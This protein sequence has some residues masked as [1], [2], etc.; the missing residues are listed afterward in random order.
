MPQAVAPGPLKPS[1]AWYILGALLIVAAIAAPIVVAAA[2]FGRFGRKVA[3]VTEEAPVILEADVPGEHEV[4][5]AFPG[6]YEIVYQ[7][8]GTVAGSQYDT[9]AHLPGLQAELTGPEGGDAILL[10]PHLATPS[11]GEGVRFDR[12]PGGRV[13]LWDFNVEQAGAYQ[14]KLS[15]RDPG[16]GPERIVLLIK[17]DL[18]HA[19]PSRFFE[20]WRRMILTGLGSFVLLALGVTALIVVGVKRSS[21]QRRLL[22]Q[23]QDLPD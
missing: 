2:N 17:P 14:L 19:F 6:H 15:Y 11:G 9:P 23:S 21:Y 5:L 10:E 1:G 22:A 7:Y 3:H 12:E 8:S 16:D 13:K 4:N 20:M 18:T